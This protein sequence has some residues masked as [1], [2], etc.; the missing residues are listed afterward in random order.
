MHSVLEYRG[1]T[2]FCNK[3]ETTVAASRH[4][5]GDGKTRYV[6]SADD[7]AGA[8]DSMQSPLGQ[9]SFVI[10]R[11][12]QRLTG[13]DGGL[14]LME[15]VTNQCAMSLKTIGG[16][17]VGK[18]WK[19][20]FDLSPIGDSVPGKMRF[21]LTA[22]PIETQAHGSLIA[23]RALSEPF[24]VEIAG[25]TARCRMNCAYVFCSD[26]DEIFSSA[27]VFIAATNCSGYSERLKHTVTTWKIDAAG[28]PAQLDELGANKDFA[29]LVSRLGV[30]KNAQIVN[31]APLPQ[32]ARSE[33][34]RTAQVANLCGSLSCEGALNPVAT[35]YLP[36]ARTVGLQSFSEPLT[37]NKILAGVEGSE[38]Q[39][40]ADL[41]GAEGSEAQPPAGTT[42]TEGSETPESAGPTGTE[43]SE[44]PESVDPT[45]EEG[46]E[47]PDAAGPT[48]TEGSETMAS[49]D[50]GGVFDFLGW[51][52][53]TVVFGA[54]VGLGI[55]YAAG[56]FDDDDDTKPVVRSPSAP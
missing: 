45:G 51:N 14:A 25:G 16:D 11:K 56:A 8:S 24:F 20:A 34:V 47:T 18:T 5:L 15:K 44:K 48:G 49:A 43:G 32:W 12:A 9:I 36:V 28:L 52:A 42:G 29:R 37:L 39:P 41:T 19:Q 50:D 35:I 38:T 1:K 6:L 55:A 40:P 10:D 30:T 22:I 4:L 27:S 13:A 2:Q 23:V 33:G 26:F 46:S 3:T 21:T 31:A 17:N 54:G 7:I 53:P